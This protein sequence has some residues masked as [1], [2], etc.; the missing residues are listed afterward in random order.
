MI[1]RI[2]KRLADV[3]VSAGF[4]LIGGAIDMWTTD[5][6]TEDVWLERRHDGERPRYRYRY[7]D[8]WGYTRYRLCLCHETV[9]G[10]ILSRQ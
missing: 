7:V 8:G 5:D 1:S 6:E 9:I 4:H 3:L 2:D 10:W